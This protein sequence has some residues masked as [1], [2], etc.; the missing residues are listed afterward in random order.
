MVLCSKN[1]IKTIILISGH[2]YGATIYETKYPDKDAS[3]NG[4]G[5]IHVDQSLGGR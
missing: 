5:G 1:N 3:N 4:Q 2:S